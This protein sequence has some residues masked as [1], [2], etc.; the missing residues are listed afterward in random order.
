[1]DV[2]N[3]KEVVLFLCRLTD[4]IV[5]SAPDGFSVWKDWGNFIDAGKALIPA[6]KDFRQIPK[7]YAD[8][9]EAE[10]AEIVQMVKDEFDIPNDK[11]EVFVEKAFKVGLELADLVELGMHTF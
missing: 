4:G 2:Q 1:M 9:D 8:M 5:K 3:I 7:E 10:R 6:I 11:I